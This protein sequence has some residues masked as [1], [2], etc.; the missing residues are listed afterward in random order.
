V[1]GSIEDRLRA[2][3]LAVE[4]AHVA[5]RRALDE[6]ARLV[7]E[8]RDDA[9]MTLGEIAKGL[10]TPGRTWSTSHVNSIL[11]GGYPEE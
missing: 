11:A 9:G 1:A 6:R 4:A 10:T 2:S 7:C 8:A 5:S 3:Q